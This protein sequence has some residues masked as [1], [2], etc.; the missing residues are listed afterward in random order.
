[1]N[2]KKNKV[3]K[4]APV[5]IFQTFNYIFLAALVLLCLY[6]MWYCLMASISNP[7]AMMRH[8]G[9]LLL[10]KGFSLASYGKVFANPNI[11]SGYKN[12]IF[13]LVVGVILCLL[14]TSLGAYVLSRKDLLFRKPLMM[15]IMFTMFFTGGLIPT[16][17]N[18]K[19]LHLT[20]SLWGLIIPFLVNTFNLIILRTSF[21]SIPDS[22]IEAAQIDGASHW[23][24]LISIV[25]PLSKATLAVMVLYYGVEKWNGWFWASALIRNRELLPLQVILREILLSSTQSMQTGAGA[26]D[27]EAIGATIRYATTIVATVPILCVYPFVQKHFTKGVMVGA[28]KE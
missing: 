25:L 27:T 28:V 19:E 14:M 22:L 24:I 13:I 20:N 2:M 1:M 16:Y 12:T 5:Y 3:K 26:G 7:G 11:I 21:E 15:I 4:S 8:M 17:L 10:P 6:P 18:L 23:K 9:P